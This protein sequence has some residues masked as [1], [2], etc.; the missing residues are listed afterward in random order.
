MS[1][2]CF[3][4]ECAYNSTQCVDKCEKLCGLP[5]AVKEF[6]CF[7]P[8]AKCICEELAY[9]GDVGSSSASGGG[10]GVHPAVWGTIIGVVIMLCCAITFYKYWCGNRGS[11]TEIIQ[12]IRK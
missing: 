10:G 12:I 9:V 3:Y 4:Q 7:S 5:S 2:V 1:V 6:E 11:G 8:L